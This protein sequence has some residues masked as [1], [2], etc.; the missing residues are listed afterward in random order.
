MVKQQNCFSIT[1]TTYATI[2][3]IATKQR[4]I[5]LMSHLLLLLIL[6]KLTLLKY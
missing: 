3:I 2:T 6:N 4:L 5:C 1:T